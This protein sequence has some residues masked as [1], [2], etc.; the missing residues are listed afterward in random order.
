MWCEEKSS[1]SGHNVFEY[2]VNKISNKLD[3]DPRR[4]DNASPMS[5]LINEGSMVQTCQ[6]INVHVVNT[7]IC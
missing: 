7:D 2:Q 5:S 1:N 6:N 4:D 3:V